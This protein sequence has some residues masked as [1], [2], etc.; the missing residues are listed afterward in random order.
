[1]KPAS[2]KRSLIACVA[3][4]VLSGVTQPVFVGG[5]GSRRPGINF[6]ATIAPRFVLSVCLQNI[7]IYWLRSILVL[8]LC[9]IEF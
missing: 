2:L 5:G 4:V 1:M 8:R 7:H 3:A 9:E 6:L